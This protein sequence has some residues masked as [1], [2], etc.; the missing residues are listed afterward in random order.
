MKVMIDFNFDGELTNDFNF[1]LKEK[2]VFNALMD[3]A[4]NIDNFYQNLGFQG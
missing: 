4:E 1:Y 3:R 2:Q